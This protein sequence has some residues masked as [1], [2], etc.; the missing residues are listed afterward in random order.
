MIIFVHLLFLPYRQPYVNLFRMDGQQKIQK[1]QI[2]VVFMATPASAPFVC[3][4][5]GCVQFF[6]KK[7]FFIL[8]C[9]HL[10]VPLHPKMRNNNI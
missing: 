3:V 2:L 5:V 10:F 9:A 7:C 8:Y 4:K 6:I 1:Y